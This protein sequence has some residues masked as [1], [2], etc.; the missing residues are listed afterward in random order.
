MS[1]PGSPAVVSSSFTRTTMRDASTESTVPPRRAIT[2]TPESIATGRSMPVPTSGVSRAQRRHRLALHVRAHERAVG[3]VVLEERDERG[4]HRHDLLRRHVHVVDAL[5]RHQRELVLEAAGHELVGELAVRSQHRVRLRDRELALLDR[6]QV[7]DPVGDAAVLDAPV[8]RLEEAVL[9]GA[10]VNRQRVDEA[11]VRPFRR[12][13]RAD[14]PVVRRVHVAHLESRALARQAA[15]AQR[16]D[17]PLV[18]DLGERVVL[19]HELRELRGAEE[20]LDR[21]RHRLGVDH[22]LRHQRLGLGDRQA[23]L[24]GALDA[25]QTDAEGVLR[26]LADQ[27]TRRLPR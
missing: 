23:L 2:V 20:L 9:V 12:L 27:R 16:R 11:D 14:A 4:G 22:L 1:T 7:I 8:G 26:H 5:A 3:V 10:R 21:G 25:H 6:R 18:R 17:A 15:R 19:V 24:D 13:D